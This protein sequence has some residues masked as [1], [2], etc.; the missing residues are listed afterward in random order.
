MDNVDNNYR[1]TLVKEIAHIHF[2]AL[3]GLW[4]G[5]NRIESVEGLAR[6]DMPHIQSVNL[7]TYTDNIGDNNITSVG[8]DQE[9]GVASP[10]MPQHM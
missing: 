7:G 8:S 6:V 1:A 9:G 4:L 10:I 3:T 2:T 5:G